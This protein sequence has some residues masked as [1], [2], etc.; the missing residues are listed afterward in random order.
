M[1]CT[2]TESENAT[3]TTLTTRN[4]VNMKGSFH[5][6]NIF[7]RNVPDNRSHLYCTGP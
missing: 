5:V 6:G 4:C 3:N 2:R 1:Y 7:I